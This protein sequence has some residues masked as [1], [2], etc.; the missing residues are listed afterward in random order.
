MN[1][2]CAVIY[3]A[4]G[5]SRRFSA[6]M[7][8]EKRERSSSRDRKERVP[9]Q[10]R[11]K[12]QTPL[13]GN[14]LLHPLE[15][16]PLYRHGL[17]VAREVVE[18]HRGSA[19]LVITQ[20]PEIYREVERLGIP[21]YL[22]ED[23]RL[24]ASCTVRRGLK[25][26]SELGEF[27]YFLFMAGDQ[28]YLRRETLEEFFARGEEGRYAMVSASFGERL[29]NPVMFHRDLYQDLI[30]LK[31]DEGGRK[32]WRRYAGGELSIALVQAAKERELKDFDFP[33]DFL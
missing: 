16:N 20:Y 5:N 24:G 30:G 18:R 28:P 7:K 4:A 21:V 3:M 23:S 19:L 25:E 6:G 32:V 26:A 13:E 29:G 22:N 17:D 14:K 15:G 27:D 1:M 10:D 2:N 31:G 8:A 12:P 33:E 9:K 11:E